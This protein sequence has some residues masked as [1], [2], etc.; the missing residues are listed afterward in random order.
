MTTEWMNWVIKELDRTPRG[1]AA[2][3]T[4][5]ESQ[6]NQLGNDSKT[7]KPTIYTLDVPNRLPKNAL[8]HYF[9][10]I[11]K[12]SNEVSKPIVPVLQMRNLRLS[13][14]PKVNN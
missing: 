13:N 3:E 8:I 9:S 12:Q 7:A 11:S 6:G 4:K 2:G 10:L 14:L 5:G 1:D